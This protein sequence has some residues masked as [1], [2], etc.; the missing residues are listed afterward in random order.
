MTHA[1]STIPLATIKLAT[2]IASGMWYRYMDSSKN[3][4][5]V[6]AETPTSSVTQSGIDT[7]IERLL[8]PARS[9][10]ANDPIGRLAFAEL[11][12]YPAGGAPS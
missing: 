5:A 8:S 11:C 10:V 9:L 2:M 3:Q 12:N 6:P 4:A 1:E 7:R